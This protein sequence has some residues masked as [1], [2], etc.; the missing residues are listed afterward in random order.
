VRLIIKGE[1][2]N[3]LTNYRAAGG[4]YEELSSANGKD[5][6]KGQLLAEQS[7][8][9][10]Y[11]TSRIRLKKM[12]LE[13]WWP[14]SVRP[15][16][17]RLD[18]SNMLGVCT[19]MLYLDGQTFF[20]CDTSKVDTVISIDPQRPEH[21]NQITYG[22][23][24]G[25]ISSTNANHQNDLDAPDRLNLNHKEHKRR[26]KIALDTFKLQYLGKDRNPNF[27]KLLRDFNDVLRPYEDIIIAYL[28]KKIKQQG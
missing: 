4:T 24:T 2:P 17:R 28:K 9:C 18:Y 22:F 11:C 3:D 25:I 15:P 26:R 20:H 27:P 1:E 14:Q 6:I 12:K 21:I 5:D 8:C 19:G 10:A 23:G 7:N 16:D 13:H